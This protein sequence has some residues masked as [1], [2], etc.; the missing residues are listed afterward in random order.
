MRVPAHVVRLGGARLAVALVAACAYGALPGEAEA[1]A[2]Q[3]P[4]PPIT[5]DLRAT[6]TITTIASP[7][8]ELGAGLLTDTAFVTGRVNPQPGATIDFALYGPDDARCMGPP[9]FQS[10]NVPYPVGGGPV[11]SAALAPASP[12]TYRWRATYSGDANNLPVAGACNDPRENVVV[13]PARPRTQP[14]ATSPGRLLSPFPVIRVVGRTTRGGVKIILMTVR[15]GVGDSI[16]SRCLGGAR[17]C[18][19]S[20]RT[21]RVRGPSGQVRIVRVRGFERAFRTGTVLRL[22]VVNVGRIGKFT[23]FRI[24]RGRLPVRTDRC[25]LGVVP[26]P[27]RC[28]Q[29]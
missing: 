14:P 10:I 2:S 8:I 25:V 27:S 6:P 11:S 1:T 16:V 28:P 3:Q 19:Y 13:T 18:P 4:N 15:T 23:S 26:L 20:Q 12:G 29:D 21:E 22:Y 24:V 5:N 9:L 17:R 7:N